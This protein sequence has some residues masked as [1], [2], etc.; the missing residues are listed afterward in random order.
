MFLGYPLPNLVTVYVANYT[1]TT[2]H[3]VDFIVA[4]ETVQGASLKNIKSN[5]NKIS[6]ISTLHITAPTFIAISIEN[7]EPIEIASN[8][9]RSDVFTL[10]VYVTKDEKGNFVCRTE[11]DKYNEDKIEI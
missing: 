10:K 1:D 11:V 9:A 2:L 7:S 3:A 8:V 4:N 6:G 5:S